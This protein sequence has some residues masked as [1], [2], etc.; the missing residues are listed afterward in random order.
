[1]MDIDGAL[2]KS[3]VLS[4]NKECVHHTHFLSMLCKNQVC[5]FRSKS[6]PVSNQFSNIHELCFPLRN[7]HDEGDVFASQ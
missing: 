2:D 7:G 3:K 4:E 1:M 5:M 6:E